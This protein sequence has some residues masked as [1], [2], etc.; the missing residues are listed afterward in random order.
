MRPGRQ[1]V[2]LGVIFVILYAIVYFGGSGGWRHRFEPKLGLDLIGGTRVT[3]QAKTEDGKPPPSGSLERAR[4][5]IESRVNGLGVSEAEVI[6]EGSS[7]ITVSLAGKSDDRLKSIG[8]P[9]QLRFR[10]VL[11]STTDTQTDTES[12]ASAS[13]SGSA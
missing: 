9:A 10:T 3:L 1:L 6:T 12:S 2:A 8:S 5:I 13:P 7:N 11:N 4:Q